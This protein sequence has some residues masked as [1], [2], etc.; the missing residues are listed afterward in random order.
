MAGAL[1][2]AVLTAFPDKK[3]CIAIKIALMFDA[4]LSFIND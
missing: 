4:K 3:S 2:R 1:L